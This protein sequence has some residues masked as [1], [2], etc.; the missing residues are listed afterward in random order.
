MKS[1]Q[2]WAAVSKFLAAMTVTLILTLLLVPGASAAS[3]YKVI[4]KFTGGADGGS[5][6]WGVTLDK[7]G[8]LY[9]TTDQGGA[10]GNGTVFKLTHHSDGSWTESVLYSFAGGGDGGTPYAGVTFDAHGSL[11]GVTQWGG[12]YSS[13]VVFQLVPNSGTWTENVLY[14]F[15]AGGHGTDYDQVGVTVDSAGV[16][17][18]T[19]EDGGTQ[20]LGVAYNLTPNSDGSWTYGVLHNFAGG[21]DGSYPVEGN[22]VFDKAGN[23]YGAT[24]GGGSTCNGPYGQGC[25]VIFE[26]VPNGDGT[27]K[28]KVLFRF[29]SGQYQPTGPL[30]FDPAGHIFGALDGWGGNYG[31]VFKL[32]RGANGK[33]TVHILYSFVG[34]QDGAYPAAGVVR[35]KRGDLFGTTFYG[36]DLNGNCCLGQVFE[37]VP[38]PY[39]WA[40]EAVH[41]FQGG[42]KDGINSRAGLVFDAKGNL[43]GTTCDGG[44]GT[45]TGCEASNPA[46]AGV[47]YE[48]TP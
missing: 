35:N 7:A 26:L 15:P 5:P 48:I 25:G 10:S 27:W 37:L 9:G 2:F 20:G 21:S 41:R 14:S 19:T 23:L 38:N 8:N 1:N 39:G 31:N 17:Y 3:K 28:E 4:Y 42:S 47:V 22:L 43:Y 45:E 36:E 24:A 11:Y 46:G 18:G 44:V 33:W 16:L 30:V 6:M 32:T 29:Q 34:N 40:K 12:D 13:G